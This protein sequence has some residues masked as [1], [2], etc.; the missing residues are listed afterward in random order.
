MGENCILNVRFLLSLFRNKI[1]ARGGEEISHIGDSGYALPQHSGSKAKLLL[2]VGIDK[3]QLAVHNI[4]SHIL[5]ELL[6]V[7]Y[8][9]T[10]GLDGKEVFDDAF[11]LTQLAQ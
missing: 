11:G 10:S 5:A 4:I 7:L 3:V 8:A 2:I 1:V 6:E 9:H